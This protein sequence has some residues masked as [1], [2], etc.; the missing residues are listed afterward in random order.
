M[1]LENAPENGAAVTQ[2]SA[3]A[4]VTRAS[5]SLQAYC[6]RAGIDDSHGVG[7]A[8]AVLRH[9]EAAIAA[10]VPPLAM[11]TRLSVRL[12]ALL[13]DADDKKYSPATA[14]TY[15]NARAMMEDAGADAGVAAN[16]LRMISLVSCS[17]NGNSM[18]RDALDRPEL[19]WPRWADRLEATGEIGVVRCFQ[20]NQHCGAP[21]SAEATPRPRTEAEIW[22]LATEERFAAYQASGGGSASMMVRPR[23]RCEPSLPSPSPR[24]R[25][26]FASRNCGRIITTTSCCRSRGRRPRSCAT[27]ISRR[28]PRCASRRSSPS[29][30]P[31]VARERCPSPPS[32]RWRASSP[33]SKRR[34]AAQSFAQCG[35]GE[36][37]SPDAARRDS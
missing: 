25:L 7:H 24:Q 35:G 1:T 21:L 27:L 36:L 20:Y 34:P 5:A 26:K 33:K 3:D 8:L 23:P 15:D 16:A 32:R 28:R 6:N 19:L 22:E 14:K 31:T 30:W 13:H 10:A 2:D 12:A 18:P 29:A 37:L 11:P 17:A 4:V 9:A